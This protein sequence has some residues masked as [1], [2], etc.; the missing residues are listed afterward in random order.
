MDNYVINNVQSD[1]MENQ[2][3][4]DSHH[5]SNRDILLDLQKQFTNQK[6]KLHLFTDESA[7]K[8]YL[9]ENSINYDIAN[10]GSTYFSNN[11]K[12]F[13]NLTPSGF[14]YTNG[15]SN[16]VLENWFDEKFSNHSK[17]SFFIDYTFKEKNQ[18]LIFITGH[19]VAHHLFSIENKENN[20]YLYK[21]KDFKSDNIDLINKLFKSGV[22]GKYRENSGGNALFYA[23]I[24]S[25]EMHSDM[26]VIVSYLKLAHKR[27]PELSNII[28]NDM[29]GIADKRKERTMAGD[30]T[31]I[32]SSAIRNLVGKLKNNNYEI[33]K[34]EFSEI[35]ADS[36]VELLQVGLK[37]TKQKDLVMGYLA[38]ASLSDKD[39]ETLKIDKKD[40][41]PENLN[42]KEFLTGYYL[43]KNNFKYAFE[44]DDKQMLS[45]SEKEADFALKNKSARNIVE[46]DL[47]NN[48]AD[49]KPDFTISL[50]TMNQALENINRKQMKE[51]TEKLNTTFNVSALKPK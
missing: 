33:S 32:T 21:D 36:T 41:M 12:E 28:A 14:N 6:Q 11:K 39:I 51:N 10:T 20:Q 15:K 7:L 31:H 48:Y 18:G 3:I 22:S 44:Y 17:S 40:L 45:N 4:Y 5:I 30:Y 26:T 27:D 19:E 38:A 43:R 49:I 13:V 24:S 35:I 9:R 50:P 23:G 1:L 16:N 47:K 25:D 42:N 2:I 37:D 29:L 8:T 46:A 34:N